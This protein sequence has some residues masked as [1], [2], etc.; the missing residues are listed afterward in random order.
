M[1]KQLTQA[2]DFELNIENLQ[3]ACRTLS[4]AYTLVDAAHERRKDDLD[5]EPAYMER[6]FDQ[7][8]KTLRLAA[9][10]LH[11]PVDKI[12]LTGMLE[13]LAKVPRA[14]QLQ[15]LAP[16]LADAGAVG[17]KAAELLDGTKLHELEFV[18][19][20]LKMTP[21]QLAQTSD[22]AIK[23][24]LALYP[25]YVELRQLG[26]ERAGQL[27]KLYGELVEVK[28][29]FMSKSFIPDANATLR[30]TFGRIRNYSP[31]DGVIKT[32]ITTL[33]GVID[34]TTGEDPFITPQ[35]VRDLYNAKTLGG[36]CIQSSARYLWLFCMTPIQ[37]V[38]I[39]A[40][41]F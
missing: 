31:E 25:T 36:L 9:H 37:P 17:S 22:P 38:V 6:N 21:D 24:M 39:Q 30:M 1:Y 33:K 10:D 18:E 5:R 12:L 23:L 2:A 14:Q 11:I 41:P 20:C 8:A 35:R 16:I 3:Q 7:T 26:K 4:V 40:V 28:Q 27:D 32:P 29:Q 34:K 19:S 15:P 13:R